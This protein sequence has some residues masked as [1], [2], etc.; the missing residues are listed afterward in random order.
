MR[1]LRYAARDEARAR[2][3]PIRVDSFDY[4]RVGETAMARIHGAWE[5]HG[6]P[7][8]QLVLVVSTPDG[9]IDHFAAAADG[10]SGEGGLLRASFP[11]DVD[12]TEHHAASFSLEAG[13][14]SVPLP[15]PSLEQSTNGD[16]ARTISGD[17]E[18]ED[19]A[20]LAQE[21]A[22]ERERVRNLEDR[23][24]SLGRLLA[25]ARQ[26]AAANEAARLEARRALIR[27]QAERDAT[28]SRLRAELQAVE[29]ARTSYS[30][31]TVLGDLA[32]RPPAP[33]ESSRDAESPT[34]PTH[35]DLQLDPDLELDLPDVDPSVDEFVLDLELPPETPPEPQPAPAPE[36]AQRAE[37]ATQVLEREP[38]GDP[39]P[40]A[41]CDATGACA[42]CAGRR[43]RF[44]MR[45]TECEG[46]GACVRCGGPGYV[47]PGEEVAPHDP[48][49]Y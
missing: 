33:V 1:R 36:Q 28:I 32:S 12:L 45:C 42:R 17:N 41:A 5:H 49:D 7:P 9:R 29:Y 46:S 30:A 43:R 14:E 4:L 2:R 40:C 18:D 24:A 48:H 15:S 22:V 8:G 26:D 16:G 39:T 47:W 38:E 20:P 3:A 34:A 35:D 44:G 19:T 10:T 25:E 27:A 6:Q 23:V 11:I 21:L 31:R 37:A 13:E